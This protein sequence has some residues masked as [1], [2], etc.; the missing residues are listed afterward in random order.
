MQ[1]S[2]GVRCA[3]AL[4]QLRRLV[5]WHAT[6][7]LL[8]CPPPPHTHAPIPP[9][10]WTGTGCRVLGQGAPCHE[11]ACGAGPPALAASRALRHAQSTRGCARAQ[12]EGCRR[13]TA[14]QTWARERWQ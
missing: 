3:A 6:V 8:H 2:C 4:Q 12:A 1:L 13:S 11:S 7:R 9:T 10:C 5:S 14:L